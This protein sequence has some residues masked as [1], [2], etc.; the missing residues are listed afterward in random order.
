MSEAADLPVVALAEGGYL[1]VCQQLT[2]RVSQAIQILT[3]SPKLLSASVLAD[4]SSFIESH[5][6]KLETESSGKTPSE[7]EEWCRAIADFQFGAG[8]G[9]TLFPSRLKVKVPRRGPTMIYD[10]NT[11]VLLATQL[12][13]GYLR[14][15]L[16]GAGRLIEGKIADFG[17]IYF[18]GEAIKGSSLFAAGVA[19][20][21]GEIHPGDVVAVLAKESNKIL[22]TAETFVDGQSMLRMRAGAV[23]K[24]LEKTGGSGP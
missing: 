10:A 17:R 4:L 14:I 1:E 18:A 16:D 24:F 22:A 15:Q 6:P 20:V 8:A 12:S 11:S 13:S 9:A 19:T 5:L 3:P 21:E 2:K 7:P 23:A